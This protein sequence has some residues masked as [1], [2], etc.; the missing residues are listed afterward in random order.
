MRQLETMGFTEEILDRAIAAA[1]ASRLAYLALTR[2]V[3]DQG[4][5]PAEALRTLETTLPPANA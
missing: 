4:M 1:G 3:T 5:S 2:A